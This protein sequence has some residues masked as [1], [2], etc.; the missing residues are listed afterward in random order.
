[1]C[2]GVK[3]TLNT[4]WRAFQI[5]RRSP[6]FSASSMRSEN[7][8][9]SSLNYKAKMAKLNVTIGAESFKVTRQ[10]SL[11]IVAKSGCNLQITDLEVRQAA[12]VLE[13]TQRVR[14]SEARS[15]TSTGEIRTLQRGDGWNKNEDWNHLLPGQPK[16]G[17]GA[18]SRSAES[19]GQFRG[20]RPR[21]THTLVPPVTL[22][23][24]NGQPARDQ[25]RRYVFRPQHP[26]AV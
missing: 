12:F 20:E 16:H 22:S 23:A 25:G 11:G 8:S 1:M 3:L 19:S 15:A 2:V 5:D 10:G 14:L 4:L 21:P 7:V 6:S 26:P 17:S 13:H 24:R 18:R 9:T